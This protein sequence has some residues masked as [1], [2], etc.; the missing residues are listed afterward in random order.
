MGSEGHLACAASPGRSWHHS[1]AILSRAF[2]QNCHSSGFSC[3]EKSSLPQPLFV[4]PGRFSQCVSPQ[5]LSLL[6]HLLLQFGLSLLSGVF[7]MH[8]EGREAFG[9]VGSRL[10]PSA[11]AVGGLWDA[12][13]RMGLSFPHHQCTLAFAASQ[14]C[15]SG[16]VGDAS[17]SCIFCGASTHFP[18]SFRF[19]CQENLGPGADPASP[20]CSHNTPMDFPFG[21][22]A[23]ANQTNF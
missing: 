12:S 1:D 6:L 19:N 15:G 3:M 21:G 4:P 10:E 16:F 23:Q 7:L 18:V 14:V 11:P 22:L 13:A 9:L 20:L 8:G 5:D 17:H 2:P